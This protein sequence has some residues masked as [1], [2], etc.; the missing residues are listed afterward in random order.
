MQTINRLYQL[1]HQCAPWREFRYKIKCESKVHYRIR[2]CG[3]SKYQQFEDKNGN[4]I[5][6]IGV[7]KIISA[8]NEEI[9]VAIQADGK[10]IETTNGSYLLTDIN[11]NDRSYVLKKNAKVIL[12]VKKDDSRMHDR[13]T[14]EMQEINEEEPELL[15]ALVI[16]IDSFMNAIHSPMIYPSLTCCYAPNYPFIFSSIPTLESRI[17]V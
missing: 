4:V 10:T 11:M 13:H 7:T 8:F 2:R 16:L 1:D 5:Y 6:N 3:F 12:Q 14:I 15:F 9:R 17:L